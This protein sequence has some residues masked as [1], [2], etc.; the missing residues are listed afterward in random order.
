MNSEQHLGTGD[1]ISGLEFIAYFIQNDLLIVNY[2]LWID[3]S[4]FANNGKMNKQNHRYWNET[5]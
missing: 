4:K 1:S 5:N 3:E 2:I